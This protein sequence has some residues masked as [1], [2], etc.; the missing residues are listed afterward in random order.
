MIFSGLSFINLWKVRLCHKFLTKGC[1]SQDTLS[2]WP[3]F[4]DIWGLDLASCWACWV[5]AVNPLGFPAILCFDYFSWDVGSVY[6]CAKSFCLYASF[7]RGGLV[8]QNSEIWD[9]ITYPTLL[10]PLR[11]GASV[12]WLLFCLGWYCKFNPCTPLLIHPPLCHRGKDQKY[13][14]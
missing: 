6:N 4:T 12:I 1:H 7:I 9:V 10:S 5:A 14:H 8:L 2:Y 11:N 13:T 3:S